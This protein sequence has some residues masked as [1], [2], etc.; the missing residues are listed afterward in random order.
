[1]AAMASVL[2]VSGTAGLGETPGSARTERGEMRRRM[3]KSFMLA[4]GLR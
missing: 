2:K 1:M 3:E 4:L